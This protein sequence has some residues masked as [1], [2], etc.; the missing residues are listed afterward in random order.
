MG[1]VVNPQKVT[2]S[3]GAKVYSGDYG[4]PEASL[5]ALGLLGADAAF[6]AEQTMRSKMDRFPEVVVAQSIQAQ[7]A[8]ME[9]V[10]REWTKE[11]LLTAWG[12][13][14]SDIVEEAGGDTA[15]VD[16]TY[17]FGA[18]DTFILTQPVKSGTSLT[19]TD[20]TGVT[21][22]VEGTDF[23]V[24]DRDSEG[25]TVVVRLSTGGSIAAG[26]SVLVDYTYN[27]PARRIFPVGK[28]AQVRYR[29]L[30]LVEPFTNGGK[31]EIMIWKAQIGIRGS[32]ALNA[33]ENGA[34][35]PIVV[36][37]LFDP[38]RGELA[39]LRDYDAA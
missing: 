34:D 19:I 2:F 39:S 26:E 20:S 25:R 38:A 24:I 8:S 17:V 36:N 11:S 14:Q 35:L 4:T 18:N 12:L 33:A 1:S 6:N 15:V 30:K 7:N 28:V 21:T 9:L 16:E 13:N 5:A 3:A 27:L 37:A 22:Y 10:L 32:L 29:T 23:A 31:A